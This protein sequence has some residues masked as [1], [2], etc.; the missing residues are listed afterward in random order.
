MIFFEGETVTA[1]DS[2][3]PDFATVLQEQL[4]LKLERIQVEMDAVVIDSGQQP[5]EN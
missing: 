1:T 3:L 2:N 4:R 5:T